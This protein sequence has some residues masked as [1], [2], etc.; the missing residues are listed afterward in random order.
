MR[1]HAGPDLRPAGS[2]VGPAARTSTPQRG[3]ICV[4]SRSARQQATQR[5][6]T[7]TFLFM[8]A[9]GRQLGEITA[10]TDQGVI[11]TIVEKVYPVEQTPGARAHVESG[12]TKPRAKS[13]FR[14]GNSVHDSG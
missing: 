10:L 2:L 3:V 13:S 14:S 5:E 6:V 12:R 8:R 1:R 7:Y 4:L 9:H 11:R